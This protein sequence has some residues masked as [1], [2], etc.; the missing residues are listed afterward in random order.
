MLYSLAIVLALAMV[1]CMIP[2]SFAAWEISGGDYAV[3]VA[4]WA[5]YLVTGVHKEYQ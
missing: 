3:N 5:K 4:E 1:L 2:T